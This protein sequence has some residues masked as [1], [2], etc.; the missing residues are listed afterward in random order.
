MPQTVGELLR[1]YRADAHL[2][3]KELADRAGVSARTIGNIETGVAPWPNAITL[4]LIA[5]ALG[6]D[7]PSR[8]A[9]RAAAT[10]RGLRRG[11]KAPFPKAVELV[12]RESQ[13]AAVR[14]LLL[15]PAT[16]LVTL[17]GGPGV[18]KTALAVA[19]AAMLRDAFADDVRFIEFATLT[20]PLLMPTKIAL[21]LG[22][23]DVRG[24]SATTSLARALADRSM[25]LVLDNFERMI[26]AATT[27]ANL[28]A[29]APNLK[30]LVTSRAPLHLSM[31]RVVKI[32]ALAPS[33]GAQLLRDRIAHST[34]D[35]T[36]VVD[37]AGID[38]L[39]RALGGIPLAI[40]LSVPLLRN[41]SAAELAARFERPLGKLV[42]MREAIA[43]SYALLAAGVQ[44]VFRA[45]AVFDG[46][47]DEDG[48]QQVVG[49]ENGAGTLEVLRAI[50][51]L[52]DRS[53]VSVVEDS[54]AEAEFNLHPL[55]REFALESLQ[56]E[57]ENDA[58]YL[59]LSEYCTALARGPRRPEPVAD[60]ATRARQNRES[61]HF[62]AA[63]G[64]L[65][66]A[67][68][69]RDALSLAIELWP[70]WY[71]RGANAHGYEWMRSLLACQLA[72]AI[73]DAFASD[74]HWA[75]A[76]LA[77]AAGH[78]DAAE[79][80]G[81]AAL[82]YKRATGDQPAVAR[83]LAGLG[84]CACEK[85][86]YATARAFLEESLAIR[87]EIGD[88]L[89]VARALVDCGTLASDEGK[90]AEANA[91]LDEALTLYRQAKRR[92]G[93]SLTVGALALVAIRSNSPLAGVQL[94]REALRAA[95]AIGFKESARTAK[96]HLS[97]ALSESDDPAQ[98]EATALE[99]ADADADGSAPAPDV[100]RLLA[101]I[102]FQR[103]R[104]RLAARLLGAAST[105]PPVPVMPLVDR[106]KHETLVASVA[107]ALGAE[108]EH[109][110][111][112]GRDG[113]ARFAVANAK[114][115]E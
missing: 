105:A 112:A 16:R 42:A 46:P 74:V 8:E 11:T 111:D 83:M 55:V 94:A 9:I 84:M 60:P 103:G 54:A 28:V 59:R 115:G 61:A 20:D 29:A 2:S 85:G 86:D 108:F 73:D 71:L 101:A 3:Q 39:T 87:R 72:E 17:T 89:N 40:E 49:S 26:G 50:A 30:V 47:F 81:L 21:A 33:A 15:D 23:S 77:Q 78:V 100:L 5:E 97:R 67:G 34:G 98:A 53:L 22:V 102:E 12:G 44:R 6:L 68:R 18:G 32:D 70:I 104:A 7:S 10:R 43:C 65:R 63:L 75:A 114:V 27:I 45:L 36:S 35:T 93:A 64:W 1:Q 106:P 95:E 99:V 38:A 66:A 14:A 88:G 24:E 52:V 76:G 79:Q 4:S 57:G 80:H 113:G 69:I 96:L 90:F 56:L 13:I 48:L 31:E 37:D 91:R 25:L 107:A 109:E 19:V 41:A 110:W 92:M 62:D 82:P 51:A 58:A